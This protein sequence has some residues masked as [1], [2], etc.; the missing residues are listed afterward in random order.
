VAGLAV[1]TVLAAS[2]SATARTATILIAGDIAQGAAASREAATADLV[3]ARSGI[4]MTAGDNAYPAGSGRDFRIRYRPTWGRFRARTHATPG[5]HDYDTPHGE[6]YFDYFGRHAG[7]RLPN[8]RG[9]GYYAFH[10]G[11]WLVLSLD[12][13]ACL[14]RVGC[15][16]GSP[17]H[18]W[19]KRMLER[20]DARCTMAIWHR[21]LFSS[22]LHGNQ[23]RVRPLARLLYDHGAEIVVNGHDHD[24]ERMAPAR[25]D[26]TIDRRSGL[27]QF[28]V[29]TG[30]AVLRS[31]GTLSVPHR[32]VFQSSAHGVLRLRLDDSGYAWS[33]LPIAGRS[34]EDSG[35]GR[36]H[37]KPRRPD[38]R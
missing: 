24:Y 25:P 32:R 17:Q 2:L 8:G 27:R 35:T 7:P 16:S 21:P 6:G 13:E 3:A 15:R 12:S 4:V 20:A 28:I 1:L 33:F 22:G 19:L 26:G 38:E 23:P 10:A 9:R 36:C 11:S 5:N 34:F 30:G 31:Q 37:G 14:R 18:T 29:G